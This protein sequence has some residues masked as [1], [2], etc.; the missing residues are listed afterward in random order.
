MRMSGLHARQTMAVLAVLSMLVAAIPAKQAYS[1]DETIE[2]SCFKG[3]T[4]EGSYVGEISVN[5]P[6]NAARDC[7]LE[8]V[9]DCQGRCL[10]CFTDS[11]FNQ[12]CFDMEGNKIPQGAGTKGSPPSGPT[13]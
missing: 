13:P 1:Q 12:V 4:D 8:Y 7:N 10:G 9:E 5:N 3:N 6:F 11:N 2:V